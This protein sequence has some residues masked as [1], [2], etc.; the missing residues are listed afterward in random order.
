MVSAF[1]PGPLATSGHTRGS[2]RAIPPSATTLGLALL[3]GFP[4]PQLSSPRLLFSS[5]VKHILYLLA[6]GPASLLLLALA[7]LLG[8]FKYQL[9]QMYC[10]KQPCRPPLLLSSLK[11]SLTFRQ[12]RE[13]LSARSQGGARSSPSTPCQRASHQPLLSSVQRNA[14]RA[15]ASQRKRLRESSELAPLHSYLP[16]PLPL[17]L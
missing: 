8:I 1:L 6:P 10:C 14:Q 15:T 12:V 5:L 11:A 3:S 2:P 17:H 7:S 4:R 13:L 9:R 16:P